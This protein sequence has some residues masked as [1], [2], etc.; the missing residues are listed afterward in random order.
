MTVQTVLTMTLVY[1]F[2]SLACGLLLSRAIAIADARDGALTR[3]I[4]GA[5]PSAPSEDDAEALDAKA[6]AA[7][8]ALSLPAPRVSADV[9]AAVAP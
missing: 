4:P 9:P 8:D 1:C 6:P 2:A 5:R 3:R 7:V